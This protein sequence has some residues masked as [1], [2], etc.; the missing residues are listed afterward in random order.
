MKKILGFILATFLIPNVV[1]AYPSES[2]RGVVS[3]QAVIIRTSLEATQVLKSDLRSLLYGDTE[4]GGS[5]NYASFN[6][7]GV[8]STRNVVS[9][10][11]TV[12]LA[13]NQYISWLSNKEG[14]LFEFPIGVS[15]DD[16][17]IIPTSLDVSGPATFGEVTVDSI[18]FVG[19]PIL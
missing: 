6:S 3:A 17:F 16:T 5:T 18:N 9:S 8:F 2:D 19:V 11:Y 14:H 13:N 15:T 7:G 10:S 1:F 12:E 4:I